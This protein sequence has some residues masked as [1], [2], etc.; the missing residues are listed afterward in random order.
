MID[1]SL[2]N[3]P[4][5]LA[6]QKNISAAET[7][8]ELA[9]QRYK[10]EFAVDLTYGG[11]G[12]TNPDGSSRT[13]LLTLMVV[14]DVP[15]FTGNRQD[16]VVAAQVAESSAVTYM[17]DDVL[18]RMRSEV[19]YHVATYEKQRERI[20]LFENTLLPQ[21]EFS[22]EASLEA[23]QSAI[24]DLTTLLRTRITEFDLQLEH[25]R[26]QAEVLKTQA[27]LKYLEGA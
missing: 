20:D 18:R 25:A 22:S 9:R 2:L 24:E 27:R 16:R 3:H 21:A 1:D 19:E 15:L 12:G 8:V 26:L 10:P 6:L 11:R 7:G 23:Y 4:R 17:R 13:D 5:I 14:M